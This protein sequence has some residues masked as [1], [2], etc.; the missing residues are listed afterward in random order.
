[1]QLMGEAAQRATTPRR[2]ARTPSGPAA[3]A[4]PAMTEEAWLARIGAA[5]QQRPAGASA[6]LTAVDAGTGSFVVFHADSGVPL[7]QA[8][9]AKRPASRRSSRSCT[10]GTA[11]STGMQACA[12][13][14]NAGTWPLASTGCSWS[15]ATPSRPRAVRP[16]PGRVPAVDRGDRRRSARHGG[17]GQPPGVRDES[18]GSGASDLRRGRSR[19]GASARGPGPDKFSER[20]STRPRALRRSHRGTA[21]EQAWHQKRRSTWSARWT[22][23]KWRTP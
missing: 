15:R 22:S 14:T 3:S 5:A 4:T 20:V 19:A 9:A 18:A 21:E 16:H 11:P 12:L 1:M 8:V 17:R 6:A 10:R 7:E 13:A 2:D 23:R